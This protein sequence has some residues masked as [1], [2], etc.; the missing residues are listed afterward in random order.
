MKSRLRLEIVQLRAI[1]V[2]SV[3]L[4]HLKVPGFKGGFIGVDVFFVISGYL[5]TGN[6]LRE[7]EAGH[8]SFGQF[9]LRRMRRIYPALIFTVVATYLIGVIWAS[10]L[11]LLDIAKESRHALLSIANV[12]Y[13]REASNY[14]AA[15]SDEL[16]MLHFWS[17]SV[18]EQYYLFAPAVL[19]VA[20]RKGVARGAVLLFTVVSLI[21]AIVV[22]RIDSSA[23]FFLTPFRIFEFGCGALVLFAPPPKTVALREA[24]SVVGF[25]AIAAIILVVRPTMTHQELIGL[26]ACIGAATVIWAGDRT[27]ASSLLRLRVILAVGTISYSLYL[28]HWPI[29]FYSRFIVGD[30]ADTALGKLVMFAGMLI[31]A[32]GMYFFIE[33]RFI[34][35]GA[36]P[37]KPWQ[38]VAR[39]GAATLTLAAAAHLTI[40]SE[41]I[42]WRVPQSV[43]EAERLDGPISPGDIA[44]LGGLPTVDLVGDSHAVMYTIGL[45]SLAVSSSGGIQYLGRPGCPILVGMTVRAPRRDDCIRARDDAIS[46]LKATNRPLILILKWDAYDDASVDYNAPGEWSDEAHAHTKLEDALVRTLSVLSRDR[47]VLLVGAQV[48]A[49]CEINRS[50][51]VQGPL[52]HVPPRPCAPLSLDSA[53]RHGAAINEMLARVQ[54]NF[55]TRIDLI[56][57]VDY[58]CGDGG[59]PSY[60]DGHWLYWE[61]THFTL[62]GSLYMAERAGVPLRNFIANASIAQIGRGRSEN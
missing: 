47:R 58:L 42:P 23:A 46:G 15:K 48:P 29:I 6:I 7:A 8:F 3:L 41:G 31:V 54:G 56:R 14:F 24:A 9:Y 19:I 20:H 5:I 25:V 52:P 16:S 4:F 55:P 53:E 32:A 11:L 2:L 13:W 26:V 17:L 60:S 33:R 40:M 21:G 35:V 34:L 28:C 43:L 50:R 62:A 61:T 59:C 51:L 36:A 49:G 45:Q 38:G 18:E 1:A 22:A 27:A 39:Y 12:Q 30:A 10:P 44:A 37:P 57:P